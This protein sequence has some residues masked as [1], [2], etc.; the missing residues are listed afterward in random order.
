VQRVPELVPHDPQ[1]EQ[2]GTGGWDIGDDRHHMWTT[3][4][5]EIRAAHPASEGP[6]AVAE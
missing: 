2:V 4:G 6:L 5:G 3:V 1:L